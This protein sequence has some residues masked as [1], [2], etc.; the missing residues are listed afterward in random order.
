MRIGYDRDFLALQVPHPAT[1][2]V[3]TTLLTDP[4][5]TVASGRRTGPRCSLRPGASPWRSGSMGIL[6]AN[7]KLTSQPAFRTDRTSPSSS[8][9]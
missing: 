1:T 7:G 2:A 4:Q 5:F 3:A 9:G 6:M 8:S